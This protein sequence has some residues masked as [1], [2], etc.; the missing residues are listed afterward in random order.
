[1]EKCL[2]M[3]RLSKKINLRDPTRAIRPIPLWTS[4]GFLDV[5]DFNINT[6]DLKLDLNRGSRTIPKTLFL[7]PDFYYRI[8][9]S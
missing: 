7:A 9:L 5:V 3:L 2:K 1:M 6:S 8:S 4:Q